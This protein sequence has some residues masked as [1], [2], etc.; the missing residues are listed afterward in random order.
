MNKHVSNRHEGDLGGKLSSFGEVKRVGVTIVVAPRR[1]H[2]ASVQHT[3]W[4]LLNILSR[5]DGIVDRLSLFCPSEVALAARVVPLANRNLDL[6]SALLAGVQAIGIVPATRGV[7]LDRILVVGGDQ[8]DL[9][10][11]DLYVAGNGWCGGVSVE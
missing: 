10:H 2:L 3:A 7:R 9:Q 4:M 1:A 5:F 6:R 8:T 11:G